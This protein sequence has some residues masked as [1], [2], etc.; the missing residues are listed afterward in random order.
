M[1]YFSLNKSCNSQPV[2]YCSQLEESFYLR[3]QF[4]NTGN[5]RNDVINWIVSTDFSNL[6]AKLD[7]NLKIIIPITE[8]PFALTISSINSDTT[9]LRI[10][11]DKNNNEF[12]NMGWINYIVSQIVDSNAVNEWDKC[13]IRKEGGLEVFVYNAF[14]DIFYLHLGY[15]YIQGF[16][17]LIINKPILKNAVYENINNNGV[18]RIKENATIDP[19]PFYGGFDLA[20]RRISRYLPT[21][22]TV[23][24]SDGKF[25]KFIFLNADSIR[26]ESPSDTLEVDQYLFQS[27]TLLENNNLNIHRDSQKENLSLHQLYLSIPDKNN[28]S[29]EQYDCFNESNYLYL[30]GNVLRKIR[31]IRN[32]PETFGL[33][34]LPSLMRKLTEI[35]S[36]FLKMTHVINL[37]W[38]PIYPRRITAY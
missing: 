14:L 24:S 31:G 6:F 29:P 10:I 35:E 2:F 32:N 5:F 38:R 34:T 9:H 7:S 15:K 19:T 3:T 30:R 13:K 8:K 36:E 20:C 23:N 17:K 28:W 27:Q 37:D 11:I 18:V 21:I 16:E 33:A 1:V 22:I 12:Y 26:P 25:G 4:K